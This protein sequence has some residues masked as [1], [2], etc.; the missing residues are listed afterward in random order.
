MA[1]DASADVCFFV[2]AVFLALY[3]VKHTVCLYEYFR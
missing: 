1:R 3:S 2:Y